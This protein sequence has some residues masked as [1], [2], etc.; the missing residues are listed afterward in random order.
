MCG[1]LPRAKRRRFWLSLA[2]AFVNAYF[3]SWFGFCFTAAPWHLLQSMSKP[4]W[5]TAARVQA[6]R[7]LKKNTPYTGAEIANSFASASHKQFGQWVARTYNDTRLALRER[8]RSSA[9]GNAA[10]PLKLLMLS[11]V[12][13]DVACLIIVEFYI[14][15]HLL[16]NPHYWLRGVDWQHMWMSQVNSPRQQFPYLGKTGGH[17]YYT[18]NKFAGFTKA[19]SAKKGRKRKQRSF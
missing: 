6:A 13:F 16:A 18:I 7:C 17:H 14:P 11:G 2:E 12:C 4:Q 5:K 9:L 8:V 19:R 10:L 1:R 15:L 3:V